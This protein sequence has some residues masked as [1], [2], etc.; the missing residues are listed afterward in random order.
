MTEEDNWFAPGQ[1]VDCRVDGRETGGY[2]VTVL[3]GNYS[4]YLPTD[5]KYEI[6]EVITALFV[7][8]NGGRLLLVPPVRPA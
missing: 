7:W 8:V 4:G 2:S 3:D 5:L 6:G 1:P